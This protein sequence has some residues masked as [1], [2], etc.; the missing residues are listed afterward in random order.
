MKLKYR[1][2]LIVV[3]LMV[4]VVGTIATVLLIRSVNAQVEGA[5]SNMESTA[6][7][8]AKDLENNYMSYYG[9]AKSLAEIMN[10]YEGFSPDLRRPLYNETMRAVEESNHQFVGIYTVWRPGIIDDLDEEYADTPGTDHTGNFISFFTRESGEQEMRAFPDS[11]ALLSNLSSTPQFTAPVQRVLG[12]R[13]AFTRDIIYPIISE[14]TKTTVGVVG[15]RID[16]TDTAELVKKIRP[17]QNSGYAVLYSSE[18]VITGHGADP[19]LIGKQFQEAYKDRLNAAGFAKLDNSLKT[20][21]P[22]VS[23]RGNS[24]FVGYPFVIG[25]TKQAAMMLFFAEVDVILASVYAL[26]TF[27]SIFAG[28]AFIVTVLLVYLVMSRNVKPILAV[29]QTLRDISEGAGDLTQQIPVRSKD[30]IGDLSVFF[31]LTLEKIRD[32]VMIIKKQANA[33]SEIGHELASNMTETAA[34]VNQITAN[35]QSVKQR[36]IY[37]S[38]SVSETNATIEQIVDNLNKLNEN[39]DTQAEY[40]VI[41]STAIEK[42]LGSIK[43]VSQSLDQNTDNVK[44]LAEASEIGRSDLQEVS[45]DIQ[46]IARESAGLL[47]I[48]AVM[49]SIAGQTNLLSMNA[50]IEA[51]HAGEAGKGFAVVAD[52]IRKLAE[53]SSEQSKT[54]AAVLQKIKDSI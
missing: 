5:Y 1:L 37:Q 52:E 36:V 26:I 43:S 40:V 6:G 19:S 21:Q 28:V 33:L 38:A 15:I 20:L 7:M 45:S 54:I 31:N 9:A 4:V 49:E 17:Y 44:A 25:D 10:S 8:Y 32:L 23:R 3:V 41:S 2:T 18:G 51:A 48:N 16:M 47:E 11:Q 46:G 29:S 27:T 22:I 12:G 30:E 35:I 34:S 53:S 13:R 42:M 39:I 50:A 14:R 24:I